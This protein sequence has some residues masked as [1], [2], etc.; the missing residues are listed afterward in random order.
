MAL[1]T[2]SQIMLSQTIAAYLSKLIVPSDFFG[3]IKAESINPKNVF[4]R[5][6]PR[7]YDKLSSLLN[8]LKKNELPNGQEKS[9]KR[10]LF[11]SAGRVESAK[12]VTI[13]IIFIVANMCDHIGYRVQ[14]YF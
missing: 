14:A 12:D 8:L 7:I 3:I 9:H 13:T 4:R 10:F 6:L 2:V 11:S 5:K 1:P